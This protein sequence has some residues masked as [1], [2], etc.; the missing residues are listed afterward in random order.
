[1]VVVVYVCV[2]TGDRG[3]AGRAHRAQRWY[4]QSSWRTCGVDHRYG[5]D[6]AW[7]WLWCRLAAVALI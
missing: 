7:L 2:L 5:S 3:G 1:M 6:L 4:W